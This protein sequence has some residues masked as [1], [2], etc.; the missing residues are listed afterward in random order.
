MLHQTKNI[1]YY[2]FLNMQKK[3]F[4]NFVLNESFTFFTLVRLI[5]L[6]FHINSVIICENI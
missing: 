3:N 5:Y 4:T 1:S 6:I 2:M